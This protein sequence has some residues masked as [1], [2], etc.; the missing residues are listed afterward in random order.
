MGAV[1]LTGLPSLYN[2]RQIADWLQISVERLYTL[3]NTA[4]FPCIHVSTRRLR[5]DVDEIKSCLRE[6]GWKGANE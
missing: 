4:E 3:V 2:S 5:F 1:K 6:R